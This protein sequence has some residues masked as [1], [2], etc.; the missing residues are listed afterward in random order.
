M[1]DPDFVELKFDNAKVKLDLSTPLEPIAE[2][3]EYGDCIFDNDKQEAL[4]KTQMPCI[5]DVE[6]AALDQT[7]DPVLNCLE[8]FQDDR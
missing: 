8:P 1:R 7:A 6:L 2:E 5:L 3:V 4:E